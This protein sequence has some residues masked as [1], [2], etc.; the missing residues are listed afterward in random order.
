M[1][2]KPLTL[3]SPSGNEYVTD[4]AIEFNNLTNKGYKP[5]QQSVKPAPAQPVK[6]D[7][8]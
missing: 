6:S 7:S 2:F 8:K 5:K 3:I 4:N 1:A